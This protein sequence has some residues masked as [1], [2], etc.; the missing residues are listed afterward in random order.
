MRSYLLRVSNPKQH[1]RYI[2]SDI[3]APTLFA[4]HYHEL[5]KLA[6]HHPSARNY[7]AEA[8]Q[9][10][11]SIVLLYRILPGSCD[12]SFGIH[13]AVLAGFPESV[14]KVQ[15]PRRSTRFAFMLITR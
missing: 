15:L 9:E 12:R 13:A 1:T 8:L 2:I 5:T 7:H 10:N 14:V 6:E 3:T 11:D 4:T